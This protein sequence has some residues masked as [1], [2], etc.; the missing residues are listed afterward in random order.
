MNG[1]VRIQ[2]IVPNSKLL[3]PG[4]KAFHTRSEIGTLEHLSTERVALGLTSRTNLKKNF[5]TAEFNIN[6]ETGVL[7]ALSKEP[8]PGRI[9]DNLVEVPDSSNRIFKTKIVDDIDRAFDSE[10]KIF[11]TI[12]A[13]YP[14]SAKG[15]INLSSELWNCGSC[16][17]VIRQFTERFKGIDVISKA[18][19]YKTKLAQKEA[20][21]PILY[22]G[23]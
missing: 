13:K 16:Q 23:Q 1:L 4:N 7:K 18:G 8:K 15:T 21:V 6:G 2:A 14:T 10:V 12:A 22:Q 11:E 17:G 19:P 20:N 3:P 5:A 9:N